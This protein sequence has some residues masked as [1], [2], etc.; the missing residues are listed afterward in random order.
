MPRALKTQW[1]AKLRMACVKCARCA[2]CE[3]SHLEVCRRK[4]IIKLKPILLQ[5][6]VHIVMELRFL[7]LYFYLFLSFVIGY[8]AGHWAWGDSI[9]QWVTWKI[10]FFHS[11][12][13]FQS[14]F[15]RC[16]GLRSRPK[17][18]KQSCFPSEKQTQS[19]SRHREKVDLTTISLCAWCS[20]STWKWMRFESTQCEQLQ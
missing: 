9:T 1:C 8:K 2:R 15:N 17:R 13:P 14:H 10:A 18:G 6:K 12:V 19:N 16:H 5:N 4:Q 20:L 11:S 3:S 7:M